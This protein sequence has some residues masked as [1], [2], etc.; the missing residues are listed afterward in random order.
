M[1]TGKQNVISSKKL[2]KRLE[3]TQIFGNLFT[4][5]EPEAALL[6][7]QKTLPGPG[8]FYT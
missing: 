8:E 3:V 1:T 6:S 7:S 4:F 2:H 5:M